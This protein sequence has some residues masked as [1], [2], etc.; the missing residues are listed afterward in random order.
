MGGNPKPD[1]VDVHAHVHADVDFADAARHR[2]IVGREFAG[3]P[4][5]LALLVVLLDCCQTRVRLGFLAARRI[6]CFI[7]V[8][9]DHN[10]A[11]WMKPTAPLSKKSCPAVNFVSNTHILAERGAQQLCF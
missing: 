5:A 10:Q 11:G 9:H 2:R 6:F 4:R 1:D 8:S 7:F 3:N